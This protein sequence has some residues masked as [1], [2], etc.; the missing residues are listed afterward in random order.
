MDQSVISRISSSF[1]T[2]VKPKCCF[3]PGR[4]YG[5][6]ANMDIITSDIIA[7]LIAQY[8]SYRFLLD[9]VGL[10]LQ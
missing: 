10:L 4:F 1:Y 2:E 8:S 7:S 5:A 6:R 9:L 3:Q